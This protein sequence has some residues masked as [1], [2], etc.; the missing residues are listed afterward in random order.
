MPRQQRQNSEVD[1]GQILQLYS[2]FSPEA[3]ARGQA[4]QQQAQFA[5]QLNQAQLSA[6]QAEVGQ[7]NA[8]ANVSTEQAKT[9]GPEADAAIKVH[10]AN[11]DNLLASTDRM[12][13][14]APAELAVMNAQVQAH[15]A[16]TRAQDA[17]T[18]ETNTLLPSK[19]EQLQS[20]TDRN[21]AGTTL[22]QA[23]TQQVG[24][25]STAKRKLLGAETAK[26]GVDM[27]SSIQDKA[28]SGAVLDNALGNLGSDVTS[29]ITQDRANKAAALAKISQDIQ[30]NHNKKAPVISTEDVAQLNSND[31]VNQ[32]ILSATQTANTEQQQNKIKELQHRVAVVTAQLGRSAETGTSLEDQQRLAVFRQAAINE[33]LKLGIQSN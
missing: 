4:A 3:Q 8:S 12:K 22:D 1:L 24:P 17:S 20:A 21:N 14:L 31:P 23:Q 25:D 9:I 28:T 5:P 2:L 15:L 13:Q 18:N 33:L 11:I 19:V 16:T 26:F 32:S 10:Q 27:A 6:L 29:S 7:R 30:N